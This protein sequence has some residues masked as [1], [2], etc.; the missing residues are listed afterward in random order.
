MRFNIEWFDQDDID[1]CVGVIERGT[2]L[3]IAETIE[4][5]KNTF[6]EMHPNL[7]ITGIIT[8]RVIKL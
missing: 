3:V 7:I 5:A 4:I 2:T 8:T 1:N 6:N